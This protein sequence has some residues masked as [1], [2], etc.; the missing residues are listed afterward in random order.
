MSKAAAKVLDEPVEVAAKP[1]KP[2]DER[3]ALALAPDADPMTSE[4]LADLLAEVGTEIERNDQVGREMRAASIDPTRVDG[5][6]MRGAAEDSEFLASR[7]RAGQA[8]LQPLL[9]AAQD[10]ERAAQWHR[11]ADAMELLVKNLHDELVPMVR[12]A[13]A[14]ELEF[15]SACGAIDDISSKIFVYMKRC[16][17]IEAAAPPGEARRIPRPIAGLSLA[18]FMARKVV[19]EAP[20]VAPID[21][22]LTY[23]PWVAAG[24]AL[25]H[26]E[27]VKADEKRRADDE[28]W[29]LKIH[30]GREDARVRIEGEILARSRAAAQERRD[31][32]NG[33]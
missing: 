23:R 17:E 14:A 3:V 15:D 29:L 30:Q 10:R 20:K 32:E 5:I 18:K 4:A 33:L 13:E 11:D 31:F 12:R 19:P 1:A 21:Y 9:R 2:L 7:L 24:P 6:A 25:S 8:A 28:A 22:S 27:I 26:D 16:D